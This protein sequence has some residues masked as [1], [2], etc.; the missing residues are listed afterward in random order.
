MIEKHTGRNETTRTFLHLQDFIERVNPPLEQLKLLVSIG[1]FRFTGKT[2]KALLWE[3]NFLQKKNKH[4]FSHTPS[5]FKEKPVD[6]QLPELVDYP[7]D[8]L[9]DQMEIL[10]FPVEQSVCTRG[11]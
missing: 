3:A 6:F 4:H 5:L 11:R 7:I 10:G 1:A 9:Y 8:D 2:K